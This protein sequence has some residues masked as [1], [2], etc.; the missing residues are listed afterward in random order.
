MDMMMLTCFLTS[1][2]VWVLLEAHDEGVGN[3][4]DGENSGQC[5]LDSNKN[6]S[7]DGLGGC[8]NAKFLD[9]DKNTDD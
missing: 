4:Q 8:T 3:N 7:G 1:L 2:S 6:H 5:G 9:K